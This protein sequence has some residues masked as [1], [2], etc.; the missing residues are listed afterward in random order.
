MDNSLKIAIPLSALLNDIGTKRT[1]LK[2]TSS[3]I[4]TIADS[5]RNI[6]CIQVRVFATYVLIFFF[7]FYLGLRR[8]REST[9][10][11]Y[12][13]DPTELNLRFQRPRTRAFSR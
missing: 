8:R 11:K 4:W 2:L 1:I 12:V 3:I 7:W 5:F 13:T 9:E 10:E 6:F